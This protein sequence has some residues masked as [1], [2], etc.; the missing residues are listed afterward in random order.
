MRKMRLALGRRGCIIG[1]L[2][3]VSLFLG[4]ISVSNYSETAYEYAV[5]LK[6]ESLRLMDKAT[7]PYA[8]HQAAVESLLV[9]LDKAYEY[10]E[11]KPKNE[12]SAGQWK[13]LID[14][15]RNLLGGF[16]KRWREQAQLT[17]IYITE[18]KGLVADA[19]DS[20]SALESGKP[21][22]AGDSGK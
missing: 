21:G 20:I 19:F 14:P 8:D 9:R 6:V 3:L 1:S 13:I 12:E 18:A 22:K 4:C 15:N 11:G 5:S 17:Q 7:E 2:V 16:L 10:A